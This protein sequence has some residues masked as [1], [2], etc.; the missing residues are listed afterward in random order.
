MD[1]SESMSPVPEVKED[2]IDFP[3]AISKVIAGNKI[4]KLE[5]DNKSIYGILKDGFLMISK[6]DGTLNQWIISE[7]D[8]MGTD[9]VIVN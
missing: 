3:E 8:L 7:G 1:E 4:T 5:W 6:E 9:W 2:G